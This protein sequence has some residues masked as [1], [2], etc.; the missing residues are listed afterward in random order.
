MIYLILYC[1]QIYNKY[2]VIK[3]IIINFINFFSTNRGDYQNG[4]DIDQFSNDINE[5]TEAMLIILEAGGFKGGDINFD[6]KIR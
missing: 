2:I 3:T 6:A 1:S 4:W 5:L